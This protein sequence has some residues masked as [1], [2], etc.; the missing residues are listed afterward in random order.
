M[1]AAGLEG[2]QI[3]ENQVEK[4]MENSLNLNGKPETLNSKP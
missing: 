3:W 2:P 1:Q 4:N